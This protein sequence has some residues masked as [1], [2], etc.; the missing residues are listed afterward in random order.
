M[1]KTL[2]ALAVTAFAASSASAFT[3]YEKEGTNVELTGEVGFLLE[4]NTSKTGD[5]KR[6]GHTYLHN[7]GSK[8]GFSVKHTAQS[9]FYGL[10]EAEIGF[11]GQQF[12]KG[13]SGVEPTTGVDGFGTLVVNEAFVGL[14]SKEAGEFTIGRRAHIAGVHQAGFAKKYDSFKGLLADDGNA[15]LR[16]D[17][18]GVE[19]LTLSAGYR[20]AEQRADDKGVSSM[21]GEVVQKGLQTG[22]GFSAKFEAEG[23]TF[24]AGYT[25]ENFRTE[26]GSRHFK[27]ALGFGAKYKMS[28]VTVGVDYTLGY[29]NKKNLGYGIRL[30]AKFDVD[31]SVSVFTTYS[32][33][34]EKAANKKYTDGLTFGASYKV[35]EN[36][37]TYAQL[38]YKTSKAKGEARSRNLDAGV[39]LKVSF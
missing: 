35:A 18:K 20:F 9:G 13:E 5:A 38:G 28:D 17:Y 22:Y 10:A 7:D 26:D 6:A 8:L 36:V 4:K 39:G 1:K 24:A 29:E 15:V 2:V 31:S 11:A 27:D 32:H 37:S 3:V 16:Y 34:V 21:K 23:A 33:G 12:E 30:G 19:G 25:R 14:G